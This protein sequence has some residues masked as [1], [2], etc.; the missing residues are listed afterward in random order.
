[1][2]LKWEQTKHIIAASLYIFINMCM[3]IPAAHFTVFVINLC[4]S[5]VKFLWD[6]KGRG[7]QLETWIHPL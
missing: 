5:W 1:M 4:F 2:K 6:V 7:E 3:H